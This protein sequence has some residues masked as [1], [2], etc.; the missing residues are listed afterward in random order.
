LPAPPT[1]RPVWALSAASQPIGA[2]PLAEPTDQ[3]EPDQPEPDQAQ[4][5]QAQPDQPPTRPTDQPDQAQPEPSARQAQRA[6]TRATKEALIAQAELVAMASPGTTAA[7]EMKALLAQW[8]RAGRTTKSEDDALW[9]RFNLAQDQLF[10]RLN[11]LRSQR[12]AE[13]AEATRA[14]ESL[15]ATAEEVAGRADIQQ[16]GE[17]M[18]S[19]MAQWKQIGPGLDDRA[20]WQRFKAAQDQVYQ[21][22]VEG[23]RQAAGEQSQAAAAKRELI[24]QAQALV[25]TADLRAANAELRQLQEAFRATGYAGREQN[26]ALA[27]Q[28]RQAQ[29]DFYAWVRR[30]PTRRREA[31]EQ[32]TYGRR[33]RLVEMIEQV[34]ADIARAE[35][36]LKSTDPS[37]ARRSHGTSIT[38]TLGRS[39]AYSDTAAE[40]MR[41]RIRLSDLENQLARLDAQL[42]R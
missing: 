17:T 26:R 29:Q 34:R 8:K 6:A 21:R 2:L 24:A 30:E 3:P 39:G 4:P 20:L 31:G 40:A 35:S 11:L 25:G 18:A 13:I 42:G 1:P 36:A 7:A 16:A 10:T 38:L 19:L 9:A 5:D 37:G 12:R 22:R 28:F 32:P 15:I 23:R 27:E 41:A 14:K 33:A